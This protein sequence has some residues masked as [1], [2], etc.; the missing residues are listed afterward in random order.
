MFNGSAKTTTYVSQSRLTAQIPASDV[1]ATG[2][3]TVQ[4]VDPTYTGGDG[5]SN[6][7]SV[8]IG[9]PK[10][11]VTSTL[12][13]QVDNS[14]K[15]VI[16]FSNTGTAAATNVK[17]TSCQLGSTSPTTAL[18]ILAGDIA[19]ATVATATVYLPGTAGIPGSSSVLKANGAYD[20]G[21]FGSSLRVKVP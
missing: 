14:I 3:A 15:A 7:M 13:R 16:K 10:L 1:S 11:I 18:P 6:L 19:P 2:T 5:V 21:T 8:T 4:V 17:L 12:T 20:G 9:A